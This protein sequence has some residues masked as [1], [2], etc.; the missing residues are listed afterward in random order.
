MASGGPLKPGSAGVD[1]KRSE[2]ATGRPC[3]ASCGAS[4][5]SRDQHPL[6]IACM[7]VSHA[8]ESLANPESCVHCIKMPVRIL[9]RRWRV[10]AAPKE[11]PGLDSTV[12]SATANVK[13]SRS[14]GD[15]VD[16][17]LDSPLPD[18]LLEHY[19]DEEGEGEGTEDDASAEA[20]GDEVDDEEE[21]DAILI[22]PSRPS[23][24]LSGGT[25]PSVKEADIHEV[26]KRAAAKLGL[27]WPASQTSEGEERDLYDGKWLPSRQP[28][29]RQ[30]LPAV[31]A[32]MKEMRKYWDKPFR[33]RVPVKGYS[34]LEIHG[35][36]DLGVGDPPLVEPAVAYHLHPNRRAT[37]SSAG[38]SLPGKME[39]FTA[40]MYQKVYKSAS[41]TIQNLNTESLLAGYQSELL[42][43]MGLSLD[44]G[45]PDPAVWEEICVVADLIL[46]VSRGAVQ[47]VGRVMGLAVAGERA[48]WLNL[49]SLPDQD[50]QVIM[51]SPFDPL[52]VKGLFGEAV[53]SMQQAC[54][55]R[56]KQGEAFNLC[57]PRKPTP[58]QQPPPR[59]GFAAVAAKNRTAAAKE[60]RG[61]NVEQ[62]VSQQPRAPNQ[63]PWGKHSFAAVAAVR[64]ETGLQFIR[65]PQEGDSAPGVSLSKQRP[66]PVV[67]DRACAVGQNITL[68][69]LSAR[70]IQWR[71]CTVCPWVLTT[72]EKGYRLQFA[73]KPPVF[74]G[75]VFSTATGE[76]AQVLGTEIAS[77]LSKGAIRMLGEEETQQGF[78]SRYFVIP[79][80]GGSLRPILDL[81][82]LNA[83][84]RKYAF[85]MITNETL[86]RSIRPADWF[87]SVDLQDAYFHISIYPSHR[88]YLRF[89]FQNVAYEF[90]AMPFGLS[91]APRVFSK[92]V[93]AALTSMRNSG[94]RLFAYLDDYLL[95]SQTREMAVR[96]T[97]SLLSHLS[98]LGFS[99]NREKSVLTPTQCIEYL[100]LKLDA[101][102]YRAYLSQSRVEK[103]VQQL[104]LFHRGNTVTLRACLRISGLMASAISVVPQGLLKM[105]DFQRWVLS[106]RLDSRRHLNRKVKS[107]RGRLVYDPSSPILA[108]QALDPRNSPA[109]LRGTV[110]PPPTEGST[111]TGAGADF[112]PATPAACALG[113]A[114]ERMNLHAVGLPLRVIN[115]IQSARATSTRTLYDL[116]WRVF[117][118][119]CEEKHV[120][121]FQCSVAE[122]LCFLQEMLDKGRAFSTI[123]VY[124]AAI[125]ACHIGWGDGPIGRHPLLKRFMRGAHRLRPVSKPLAPSWDLNVVLEALSSA[126]FEPVESVELKLLSLKTV[127]LLALTTAKR[128][129][130][131]QALSIHPSCLRFAQD[132]GKVVFKANPAFIPK[133]INP[134][135]S[136][137]SVELRA[138]H[139]PPFSSQEESRLNT[140]CPVRAL[141][142]YVD[143]TKGF[144]KSNQLFVSWASTH[145]GKPV[146]R[147]RLSHWLVEAISRAYE[148]RGLQVPDGL[149]AHSTR[150]MATS[151]AL[152]RGVSVQDICAAA[153]WATPHTFVR[154]YR[155][156]VTAPSVAHSVLSVGSP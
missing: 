149:R 153:S 141:R 118:K 137:S 35:G 26:C 23:S 81:R 19:E 74:N 154:F 114:R 127:L 61:P 30:L 58:R 13:P 135:Y 76:S 151:W 34:S 1:D 115:T 102:A 87:T 90:T 142:V 63:K 29:G 7:G 113:L 50:K 129:S 40:S 120:V 97:Q 146:S 53:N 85:K 110:A 11:N 47:G 96:N 51:D 108:W 132:Y 36:S 124:L 17:P 39:R 66:T 94:L 42:Q 116:K 128:V 106:L 70:A 133:V 107:K 152:F 15:M 125:S 57:L 109:P 45:V 93:E 84:L 56:K 131:L 44:K 105:R 20:L 78:Y 2:P 8:Q 119:W 68:G 12:A 77:L 130:E 49:S 143:R 73:I 71:V 144:R 79:K 148:Y 126:L 112:P 31:P 10:S 65:P 103:F 138:F 60:P 111:D 59:S 101:V 6:C 18:N 82:I 38:P 100:G 24:A 22:Q 145:R 147:Q 139:P 5:S 99:V 150:G 54:D 32:C 46:R 95:C 3:P 75:V 136:C 16:F 28:P 33:S 91:L 48:L 9:K 62:A 27:E 92:C 83:H 104:A 86:F 25:P 4:I 88:K 117:E 43:E 67:K 72:I 121:S 122:V 80:K 155:L 140:L 41:Q 37:L 89:A 123:K 98:E 52:K 156:D 134:A 14:W 55:L 69:P 21:E 64:Q